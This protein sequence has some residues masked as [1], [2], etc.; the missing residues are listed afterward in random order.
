M[1][2]TAMLVVFLALVL[3]PSRSFCQASSS[4]RRDE[5]KRPWWDWLG[6]T[7]PSRGPAA[8]QPMRAPDKKPWWDW[9]GVTEPSRGPT[10]PQPMRAPD[11][12][13]WWDWLGV[14]DPPQPR[15]VQIVK[16]ERPWW[17]WLE[18]T[19]PKPKPMVLIAGGDNQKNKPWWDWLGVTQGARKQPPPP[20]KP[21]ADK[22]WWDWLGVT[23]K[24]PG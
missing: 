11:K 6:V 21:K 5:G 12:K 9:L 19:D 8:P 4:A 10:A 14:T 2:R 23:Q 1:T 20:K 16:P 24:K 17:D 18:V 13:P 7:E 22:P 3:P 15:P